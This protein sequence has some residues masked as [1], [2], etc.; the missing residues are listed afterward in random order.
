MINR[1]LCICMSPIIYLIM[2]I[3]KQFD[4]VFIPK[5]FR[6][7]LYSSPHKASE[8]VIGCYDTDEGIIYVVDAV[9][10][11]RILILQ[12]PDLCDR[13]MFVYSWEFRKRI[14]PLLEYYNEIDISNIIDSE[15]YDND[16]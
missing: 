15:E 3:L 4:A 13:N 8:Y 10:I 14:L 5:L 2:I 1:D 7:L 9:W 11:M 12:Y 16:K 6:Y